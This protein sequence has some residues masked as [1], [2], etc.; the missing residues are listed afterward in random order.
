MFTIM[1]N[2]WDDAPGYR[3]LAYITGALLIATGLAHAVAWLVVGGPV[4][5]PLSWRKP[6]AFGISFGL[7][8]ATLA[9]VAAYL[10]VR[11]GI[12][13]A[14]SVVLCV[15]TGYEVAWVSVQHTRGVP[16]H[17]NDTN[18]LDLGLFIMGAVA[19]AAA[20]LVIVAVTGAAFIRARAPAPMALAIRSG[21]VAL[22]GAQ[23]VGLWMLL[24]GLSLLDGDVTPLT[25]SMSTYGAAGAMKFAH[26][27]PMH[28]IQLLAVVAWL[29]SLSGLTGR[30]QLR[31]V[32]LSVVG[33]A[34]LFGIAL[35]RTVAGAPPFDPLS[36]STA[37]Y[38]AAIALL[39]GPAVVA[40][41]GTYRRITASGG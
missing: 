24:H 19:V 25:R 35:L 11:R 28:A 39:A 16:S 8:T 30:R 1:R 32:A 17:F 18:A 13:W 4:T 27:V 9:W 3:R 23:A 29:L 38:L 6:V 14:L 37:G 40:L 41:A 34:G 7:T 15:S 12:G 31:L 21:L 22:L 26:F 36:A 2:H 5:G 33:Y 10:P 20:I